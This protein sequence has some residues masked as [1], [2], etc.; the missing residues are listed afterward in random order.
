[1]NEITYLTNLFAQQVRDIV[2]YAAIELVWKFMSDNSSIGLQS[3][4]NE[5]AK[6]AETATVL[7]DVLNRKYAFLDWDVL[8]M[9][10][11]GL[12]KRYWHGISNENVLPWT[13]RSDYCGAI[14]YDHA[15]DAA[16]SA[17]VAWTFGLVLSERQEHILS[18]GVDQQAP[19]VLSTI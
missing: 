19:T 14:F 17:I 18:T 8:L 15:E 6:Y 5:H 3:M 1:M 2:N 13:G 9:P 7:T 10:K 12:L 16:K 4:V 11:Y